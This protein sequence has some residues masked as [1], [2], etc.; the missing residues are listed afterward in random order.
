M[1]LEDKERI[2]RFSR[3]LTARNDAKGNLE[4]RKK[5]L[6]LHADAADEVLLLDD[7]APVQLN[8]GD[9]FFFDSKTEVE[10]RL[11]TVQ[12]ELGAEIDSLN[13]QVDDL[14]SE[15]S[16]LKAALYAKFGKSINLEESAD[17]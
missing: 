5:L 9:A 7:D 11:E 15:I 17:D 16:T 10:S 2:N 3:L 4:R 8:V 6:Q 14:T 12:E 13:S 1:M